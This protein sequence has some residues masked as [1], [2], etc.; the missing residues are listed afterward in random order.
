[1]EIGM[2][3]KIWDWENKT[4]RRIGVEVIRRDKG[5]SCILRQGENGLEE[6]MRDVANPCMNFFSILPSCYTFDNLH[7]WMVKINLNHGVLIEK[8]RYHTVGLL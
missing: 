4:I 6:A 8:R 1:M 7:R 2:D 5:E 3:V